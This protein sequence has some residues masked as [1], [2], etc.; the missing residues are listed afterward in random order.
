[1]IVARNK[2]QCQHSKHRTNTCKPNTLIEFRLQQTL[3][4]AKKHQCH[5]NKKKHQHHRHFNKVRQILIRFHEDF[6]RLRI[7]SIS[8]RQQCTDNE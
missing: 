6:S 7:H 3:P 4:N 8:I 2:Q 1:M 5:P